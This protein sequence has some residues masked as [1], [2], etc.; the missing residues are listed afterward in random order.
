MTIVNSAIAIF[1]G[2]FLCAHP[3]VLSSSNQDGLL[4]SILLRALKSK[5]TVI[6]TYAQKI[7]CGSSNNE[8]LLF[9]RLTIITIT[10]LYNKDFQ[11]SA[12]LL[13]KTLF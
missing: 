7:Y 5:I 8:N 11:K 9:N 12:I 4:S 13:S 10:K 2:S 1:K 3:V 6:L